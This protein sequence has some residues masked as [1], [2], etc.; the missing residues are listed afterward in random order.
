MKRFEPTD[1]ERFL[2]AIDHHLKAPF[3]M[4]LIGGAAAAI[5]YRASG[6]TRDIDTMNETGP[7]EDAYLLAKKET[8]LDIPLGAARVAEAPYCYE[9]RL[10]T[11]KIKELKRLTVR[12][13]EK[14]DL[15]LMKI[16]R[17]YEH[18]LATVEELG[19]RVGLERET[20]IER[21]TKEMD[22]VVGNSTVIHR[23]F[24][25]AIEVLYGEA[26]AEEVEKRFGP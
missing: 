17:G 20:L 12:V 24:L 23:N 1:L 3:D 6:A 22:H 8:G 26:A 2:V 11:L 25:T 13:P 16:T 7:I 18:D 19:K 21:Y 9:D 5:A 14:H 4:I 15:A 10:V